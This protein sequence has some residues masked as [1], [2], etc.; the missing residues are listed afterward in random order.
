MR[1]G[2]EPASAEIFVA[3]N[4][5][6]SSGQTGCRLVGTLHRSSSVDDVDV[7]CQASDVTT[8]GQSAAF[9][10]VDEERNAVPANVLCRPLGLMPALKTPLRLPYRC[11]S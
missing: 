9:R 6:M 8:A 5:R 11:R 3:S 1:S 2:H 7:S 4:G 10:P